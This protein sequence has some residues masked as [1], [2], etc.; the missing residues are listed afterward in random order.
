MSSLYNN[1]IKQ[2]VGSRPWPRGLIFDVIEYEEHLAFRFYRE[3]F[4][5]FDSAD[6]L[7]IAAQVKEVMETIRKD[8]IPTYM[9]VARTRE[10]T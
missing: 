8:G 5:T 1:N 3:N 7:Q 9:E 10:S 6:Q 4:N 2:F